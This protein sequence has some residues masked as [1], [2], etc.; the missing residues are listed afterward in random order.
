MKK[1]VFARLNLLMNKK[2]GEQVENKMNNALIWL[3]ILINIDKLN[4]KLKEPG[5]SYENK[6]EAYR[7]KDEVIQKLLVSRPPEVAVHLYYVPYY[8]YSTATKD[9][10]G[11]LMRQ[12]TERHPFEYYLSQVPPSANDIEI[13]EKAS[14]EVV[15]ECLEQS[16]S[17]HMPIGKIEECGY[18]AASLERKAWI[19]QSTF[20]DLFLR[21]TKENLLGLLDQIP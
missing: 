4:R 10:A 3:R 17:F 5:W 8:L 2:Q 11:R 1:N 13:P 9:Q 7:L 6:Q 15:A 19:N 16:F 14:V 21:N 12:D 20:T 18:T